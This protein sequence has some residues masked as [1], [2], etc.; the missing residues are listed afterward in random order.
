MAAVRIGTQAPSEQ[1]TLGHA[2]SKI[3]CQY[4]V[5]IEHLTLQ[6]IISWLG[7]RDRVT[8]TADWTA[9]PLD[10]TTTERIARA[11]S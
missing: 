5:R 9:T 10:Y 8:I 3:D 7:T 6:T 11:H 4:G 1:L 2:R